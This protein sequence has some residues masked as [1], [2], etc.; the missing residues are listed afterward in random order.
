MTNA[1]KETVIRLCKRGD[2]V[3]V[4]ARCLVIDEDEYYNTDEDFVGA[5]LHLFDLNAFRV[6]NV[7]AY[8]QEDGDF[9]AIRKVDTDE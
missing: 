2:I 8:G 3:E 4:T 6:V 7:D 5:E 9:V 1:E